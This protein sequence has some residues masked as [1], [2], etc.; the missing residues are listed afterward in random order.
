MFRYFSAKDGV[1]LNIDNIWVEYEDSIISKN[2]ILP[3]SSEI[4][5]EI[6]LKLGKN[7]KAVQLSLQRKYDKIYPKEKIDKMPT[8]NKVEDS[9]QNSTEADGTN[10]MEG[11]PNSMEADGRVESFS[12]IFSIEDTAIFETEVRETKHRNKV[13]SRMF[14][15]PGW[16]SK[17]AMFLWKETQLSC[18]FDL[19]NSHV[20]SDRVIKV[21]A[22][23]N[24][25]SVLNVEYHQRK[26]CVDIKNIKKTFK[27]N[28]R[29]QAT[30]EL[31]KE[32]AETLKNNSA[33]KVQTIKVNEL[34]P[35]NEKLPE[36]DF[37]PVMQTL[38]SYRI[39]KFLENCTGEDED[40]IDALLNWKDSTLQNVISLVCHS[41][42]T[43][44]YRTALQLALYIA[45]SKNGRMSV[46]LDAT[47]SCIRPPRRSQK[48]HGSEKL[49]HVFLYSALAKTDS[50]S[51]P[52]A[53]MITQDQSSE[54]IEFF[55]KKMFRT[56]IK[57]PD[58]F[59]VD[60][61][62]A[63]LK[64][65]VVT[66]TSCD[67][68]AT[69]IDKC[70]SSIQTGTP[71]PECQIRLDRSHFVK[72]IARKIKHRDHR[73]RNFFRCIIGFLIT[74]DDFDIAKSIILDFFTVI[75]NEFDGNDEVDEPLPSEIS[76]K[77]L[78]NLVGTHNEFDEY[79]A[80]PT[81]N[82]LNE[83]LD[84]HAC[85]KWVENIVEKVVIVKTGTHL[86]VFYDKDDLDKYLALF[87]TI[88]LWSNIMN[89]LFGSTATVATSADV[90]SSFN[91]LKNG[92]LAG[93][94]Y[95]PHTFIRNHVEFVNAEVKLN[96]I[97]GNS[98][99]ENPQK[100]KRT[101]SLTGTPPSKMRA[102]SNSNQYEQSIYAEGEN[103]NNKKLVELYKLVV[104]LSVKIS[105]SY[106]TATST[107]LN[108]LTA[109]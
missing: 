28:R 20:N 38:N 84:V 13:V 19:K 89:S 70:M 48:M 1:T 6:A 25:G 35:D 94:K 86:N 27:H 7:P 76:R 69:Y 73:K 32:L 63:I 10:S 55:L 9:F 82:E 15:K 87:S 78:M 44:H 49:K 21:K 74:C 39:I 109:S 108:I 107:A 22:S 98:H 14:V 72:N 61:S 65:L 58:E 64:A 18:K 103:G 26:L 12:K 99:S 40:P 53:Q 77:R 16:T 33:L 104:K 52:I 11:D 57:P 92:I 24:C 80:D 100:R 67:G 47:G 36:G 59:V 90:E 51:V 79:P 43:V 85:K 45:L 42:F 91:A 102:R 29:Y 95:Q 54:N 62:K 31:K 96:A 106:Q 75:L 8:D 4:I 71:P 23:C 5:K 50:K 88:A 17:L 83:D 105:K 30:G 60:E 46:S 101:S 2:K 81:D 37:V 97:S 34:I 66:F 68:I 56:P 93:K 3:S 41:P